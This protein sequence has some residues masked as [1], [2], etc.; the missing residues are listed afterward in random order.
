M[1][2]NRR[3]FTSALLSLPFI[4]PAH[5]AAPWSAHVIAGHFDGDAYLA[6]LHI[7]LAMGWKTYW[8]NPGTAGIPPEITAIGE[9]LESMSV[10]FPMPSR[11][12]DDS[13]ETLG[14]HDEVMF[15]LR[16]KPKDPAKP[17]HVEIS[18]FFGVCQMVCTPAKFDGSLDFA[19]SSTL[20][21]EDKDIAE[22]QSQVPQ[23]ATI[24]SG[25]KINNKILTLQLKQEVKDIFIEGPERYYFRAPKFNLHGDEA[26]FVI[27]GL[28]NSDDLIGTELRLTFNAM[29]VGLEQRV[30][31]A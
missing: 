20:N 23:P 22:W 4:L 2:M 1:D 8:R 26:S 27:D 7:D 28:K 3:I 30:T 31:V 11:I 17:L 12:V 5:A 18:S 19:P 14:F 29:G 25:A 6:G 24:V 13:G 21:A 16:L 15:I 10:D 9:N